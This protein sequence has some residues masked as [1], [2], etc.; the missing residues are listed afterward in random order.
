MK[1]I[2]GEVEGIEI[3]LPANFREGLAAVIL[4]LGLVSS[5]LSFKKQWKAHA[6]KITGIL[7]L[8]GLCLFANNTWSYLAGIF[9]IATAVTR[10]EYL[11]NLAAIIR[12][13]K[14]YFEYKK[15]FVS[16]KEVFD[17][18]LQDIIEFKHEA[19]EKKDT[20]LVTAKPAFEAGV[21]E[22]LT[23]LQLVLIAE[24]FAFKEIERRYNKPIQ[25]HIRIISPDKELE[26]DGLLELKNKSIIC[27][28]KIIPHASF[29]LEP[30]YQSVQYI[31]QQTAEYRKLLPRYKKL[32]VSYVIVSTFNNETKEKLLRK[33]DANVTSVTSEMFEVEFL[34]YSF[35]ELGLPLLDSIK[36]QPLI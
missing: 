30:L 17:H 16:N 21:S 34:L 27:A 28:S 15:E 18:K 24:D 25:R 31:L 26:F 19:P 11:Q 22:S 4:V 32:H 20:E 36:S 13:N 5:F 35:E 10:T 3:L 23:P 12:G 33:L 2:I 14:D 9:I 7:L 6:L 1:E 29:P 8:L